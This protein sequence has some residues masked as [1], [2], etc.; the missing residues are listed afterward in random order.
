MRSK[1]KWIFTLLVAFT[2]QFSFAQEKTVTGVVSDELGP[3]AGANVVVRGTTRGTTTDFD[4]KFA[5]KANQN[6]VL[7][8]SYTGKKTTSLIVGESSSYSVSLQDEA[9][10]GKDVVI[11]GYRS[12]TKQTAVTSV[13]KVDSKTI[14]NRPNA[15][16][17]NTVQ[18]Q[19]AGVNITTST[20]Q[21]GAKSTVIIRGSGSINGNTDPLYVI[22]GFPSNSDN[23]RS[24]N[25]NDIESITVLKDAAAL[26]EYGNRASNGVVVIRTKR[27][28]LGKG[29]TTFRYSNQY[30]VGYLQKSDYNFS[31]AK[32]LLKVEQ[33]FGSGLGSSLTNAEIDAWDTDTDWVDFFLK[34]T[35]IN[36]HTLSIENSGDNSSSFTSLGYLDNGGILETT[37]LKRFT[38]RN[39]LVG[40]STNDRFN[41][42]VA[43]SLGFSKNNEATALGTG[44]INNNLILGSFLGAPYVSP[45]EYQGGQSAFDYFNSTPGLLATPIMLM[46][47]LNNFENTVE[48]T[49]IDVA[50]EFSYKLFKDLTLTS[51]INAQLL[52]QRAVTSQF[53]DAFNAILFS[54]TAGVSQANGGNFN[55]Q[56]TINTRR[57]FYF[58]NLWQLNYNKVINDHT[59]NLNANAEYNHSRLHV[60]TFTQRGLILGVF[61][62]NSGAGYAADSGAN[63]I[64]CSY[65]RSFTI[66]K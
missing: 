15:N 62:P 53:P 48:E 20:G 55:G 8:I 41:Y 25:S 35:T 58:N 31:N 49:R 59:F 30:G 36:D 33:N 4:G 50:S 43:T 60:N 34:P 17:M 12:V 63:D 46:D 22:D 51:R 61:S 6:E 11:Q 40:K 28:A 37:G 56:E 26:A 3:I 21:P 13:A 38:L 47:I 24:I 52:E 18:G 19:L 32:Q 65:C 39:N 16:V 1:F 5:I 2:M 10:I 45:S 29:K 7:E 66:K 23:F 44:G 54:S 14:E 42:T 27:A 57:E 9:L 64:F